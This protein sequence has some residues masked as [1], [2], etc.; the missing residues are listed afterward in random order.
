MP[1]GTEIPAT[2]KILDIPAVSVVVVRDGE[3]TSQ[4]DYFDNADGMKQLGLMPS[5]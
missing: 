1:G 3:F 5:E 4:R 2:H